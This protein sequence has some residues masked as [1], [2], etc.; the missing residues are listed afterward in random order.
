MTVCNF[1]FSGDEI[2]VL[3]DT[4]AYQD[5]K[6]HHMTLPK[7]V[8]ADNQSFAVEC[9]GPVAVSDALERLTHIGSFDEFVAGCRRTFSGLTAAEDTEVSIFGWSE[10]RGRLAA[11]RM[12]MP[13]GGG[14]SETEFEHAGQL[15]VPLP[16]VV[17][18]A[19]MVKLALAQH[20]VADRFKLALCIGGRMHLTRITR[21]SVVQWEAG[22]YPD[23][24]DHAATLGDPLAVEHD[25]GRKSA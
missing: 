12:K 15:P 2:L 24:A 25:A 16:P 23:Y 22:R 19:T 17:N 10:E 7:V 20:R 3:S 1:S 21:G 11:I 8:V 14:F 9:R 6:P 4:M 5:G 13:K 18:A